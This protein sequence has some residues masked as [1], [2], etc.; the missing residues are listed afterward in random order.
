M[1]ASLLASLPELCL[2]V[3]AVAGLL[4]GMY[5]PRDRQHLVA[6]V[7]G[8]ALVAAVVLTLARV[9]EPAR[10]LYEGTYILDVPV[11]AARVIVPLAALFVVALAVPTLRG[12]PRQTEFHTLVLLSSLGTLALAGAADLLVLAAAYLLTTI[13]GYALAGFGKDPAGVEAALKYFLVGALFAV[14]MLAGVTLWYGVGRGAGYPALA[15]ELPQAPAGTVAAAGVALAA[16]LL[17]KAGAVPGHFWVP[18]VVEGTRTPVAAFLTTVPKV[19]ALIALFRIAGEVVPDRGWVPLAA[20]VAAASMTLGNLAAFFQQ[21]PRRLLAYSTI[22]QVGYLLMAVAAAGASNLAEP[23]LLY[24]LAGYAAANLGAFAVVA[25]VPSAHRLADYRGLFRR[26]PALAGAL[27]VCLLGLVGTPPTAVFVGKL[28][29]FTAT[30]DAGLAWLMVLAA[31]NTLA[32]LFYYLRWIAPLFQP[33]E[34]EPPCA[35]PVAR[36][37]SYA[38]ATLTVALGIGGGPLLTSLA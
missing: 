10:H 30:T 25:A 8:L 19:G 18:D 15:R 13:P 12:H 21:H 14:V 24:Y 16:G 1:T 28:G 11:Q 4:F 17:F 37:L 7:A 9:R 6:A 27:L 31:I 32:S 33:G 29:L 20:T 23:M 22:S 2:L 3:G 5:L 38:A 26:R 35:E 36:R 34:A